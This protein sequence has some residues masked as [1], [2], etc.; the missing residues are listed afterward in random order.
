MALFFIDFSA[1]TFEMS[2]TNLKVYSRPPE[3]HNSPTLNGYFPCGLL[4]FHDLVPT[5]QQQL[6]ACRGFLLIYFFKE[7]ALYPH[8]YTERIVC[9]AVEAQP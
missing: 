9:T 1:L 8:T 2:A 5:A 3:D 4:V 6:S 7:G